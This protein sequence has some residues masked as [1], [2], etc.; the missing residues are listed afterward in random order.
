[1]AHPD[2]LTSRHLALSSDTTLPLG[3][4][5]RQLAAYHVGSLDFRSAIQAMWASTVELQQ[6][7]PLEDLA[8]TLRNEVAPL[9]LTSS[10]EAANYPSNEVDDWQDVDGLAEQH[11]DISSMAISQRV[12]SVHGAIAYILSGRYGFAVQCLK[13]S[14]QA[15]EEISLEALASGSLSV[16]AAPEW[17][18]CW[19]LPK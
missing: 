4:R 11:A 6:F 14:E 17:I 19:K 10:G 5:Y 16:D 15:G 8:A 3:E 12:K 9:W 7:V 2:L 1:M 13:S 18:E